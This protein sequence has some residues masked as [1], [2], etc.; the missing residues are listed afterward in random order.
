MIAK[1]YTS[2]LHGIEEQIVVV[3]ADLGR[4]LPAFHIVGLTDTIIKESSERIR[5]AIVNSGYTFPQCRITVN[6]SPADRRK[7]GSHYDLPMAMALLLASDQ[8]VKFKWQDFAF[9]GE[10]TL[11]GNVNG[12]PGLLPLVI[13]T[14]EQGIKNIVIP[15]ANVGEGALLKKASV[16]PVST[17][18]EVMNIVKGEGKQL[19][20]EE[21]FTREKPKL[22]FNQ[23]YGQENAK[24]AMV[25]AAA[26]GHNLLMVGSPGAG[27]TMLAERFKY[28]LPPLSYEEK[29]ELTKIYSVAG[30][31]TDE[32]ILNERPFRKPYSFITEASMLGGGAIPR[33]GE[34]SLAHTGV[35]FLD[36]F[37]NFDARCIAGLRKPMDDGEISISRKRETVVFPSDFILLIATNPCKCGFYGDATR[38]CTCTANQLNSFREK[39][40]T[41]LIDRVDLFV[42][43]NHVDFD[44]IDKKDKGLSTEEM[45]KMVVKAREKQKNRFKNEKYKVNSK[46][47][48][49]DFKK[50]CHLGVAERATL[51]TA[52][53]KIGLT[54]RGYY[55]IIRLSRTIADLDDSEEINM[56]HILEAL[57]Y[58]NKM[59]IKGE[60]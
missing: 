8:G 9:F 29:I 48:G 17:L 30:L 10:L 57:Q 24:R 36:E 2:T 15:K 14:E 46:I 25:I 35:L 12:I 1:T 13:A 41:P 22:D 28:L 44:E 42:E 43:M 40:S 6:L 27:K 53:E 38:A 33:P 59:E 16:F 56:S 11:D 20:K 18:A 31:L 47:E 51:E 21:V 23:V 50:Y 37:T 49:D 32:K 4:G 34:I 52:Y 5:G 60:F 45:Y 3:E 7:C 55:K 26:G 39:F 54:M 58:R 19:K